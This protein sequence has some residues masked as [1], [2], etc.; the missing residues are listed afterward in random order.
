MI[1]IEMGQTMR[2]GCELIF[3][4]NTVS[5]LTLLKFCGYRECETAA[6]LGCFAFMNDSKIWASIAGNSMIRKL[7]L[8]YIVNRFFKKTTA[9]YRDKAHLKGLLVYSGRFFTIVDRI[10]AYTAKKSIG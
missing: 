7:R 8:N 9:I 4:I 3:K 10:V 1:F 5:A 2:S 6:P